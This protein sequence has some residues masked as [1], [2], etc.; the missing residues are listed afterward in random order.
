MIQ[1]NPGAPVAHLIGANHFMEVDADLGRGIG[2]RDVRDPGILF[3]AAPVTLVGEGLAAGNP[4]GGE[5][6]PAAE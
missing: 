5:N 4:H 2:Q 1:V 3:E 6:A